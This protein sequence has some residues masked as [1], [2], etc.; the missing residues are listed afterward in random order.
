MKTTGLVALL[1]LSF[2]LFAGG[3]YRNYLLA[4]TIIRKPGVKPVAITSKT[5]IP[6][7]Q[8]PKGSVFCRLEDK[9]TKATRVW[10]KIGVQ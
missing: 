1:F 5:I 3:P 9:L 2:T 7:Y 6:R 10:V 4:K 8:T